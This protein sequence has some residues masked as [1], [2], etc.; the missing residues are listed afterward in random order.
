[1]HKFIQSD[2]THLAFA[3]RMVEIDL[4]AEGKYYRVLAG[5]V[6]HAQHYLGVRPGGPNVQLV[7]CP[8]AGIGD[9]FLELRVSTRRGGCLKIKGW[10][11]KR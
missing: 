2:P 1:M 10:I 7:V 3:D 8:G 6:A 4:G 5:C 11:C 9:G